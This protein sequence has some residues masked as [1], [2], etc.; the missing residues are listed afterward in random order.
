MKKKL[1]ITAGLRKFS[2]RLFLFLTISGF[3]PALAQ[4]S[5]N[6]EIFFA[7]VDSVGMMIQQNLKDKEPAININFL[8]SPEYA[9]L[10]NRLAS[11]L[12][13]NGLKISNNENSQFTLNFVIT[14]ALVKYD[15]TFRDGLFGDILVERSISLKGNILFLDKNTSTD[16]SFDFY[17]T[18]KYDELNEIENRA[19]S[20]TQNNHPAE[21]F[22]SSLI[23]PVIAVGAAATAVILFFTIRSK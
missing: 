6:L 10:E 9:I 3:I 5:S 8:S 18:V 22:F 15:D 4:S 7:Q 14:E 11:Y 19:Y 23:E 1:N 13:K 16:F 12:V 2:F 17:D 21:P 20:F